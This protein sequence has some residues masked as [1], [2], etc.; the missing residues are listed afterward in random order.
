ML[1]CSDLHCWQS[2]FMQVKNLLHWSWCSVRWIT[3]KWIKKKKKKFKRNKNALL[4]QFGMSLNAIENF[5]KSTSTMT[6][7]WFFNSVSIKLHRGPCHLILYT[8]VTKHRNVNAERKLH[9][10]RKHILKSG[11]WWKKW[12]KKSLQP[13]RT[14][15]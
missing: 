12:R 4:I 7:Y 6:F 11:I 3:H 13:Q 1:H 5:N 2:D 9:S 10:D 8:S 15:L 14:K